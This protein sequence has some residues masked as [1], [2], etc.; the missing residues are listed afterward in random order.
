MKSFILQILINIFNNKNVLLKLYINYYKLLI[1]CLDKYSD[2]IKKI[3]QKIQKKDDKLSQKSKDTY[4]LAEKAEK[5]DTGYKSFMYARKCSFYK[6]QLD[7]L[8]N[9]Y[10]RLQN[11]YHIL[12]DYKEITAKF[13]NSF[14]I[15][16]KVNRDHFLAELKNCKNKD[17]KKEILKMY[18]L[19]KGQYLR[20]IIGNV[21]FFNRMIK[22]VKKALKNLKIYNKYNKDNSLIYIEEYKK[23]ENQFKNIITKVNDF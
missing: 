20:T 19:F 13:I 21:Y 8:Q 4:Y 2:K 14:A 3:Q 5:S 18:N 1:S 15:E 7:N 6:E 22:D 17:E 10:S 23:I 9:T 12:Q 16:F 11:S